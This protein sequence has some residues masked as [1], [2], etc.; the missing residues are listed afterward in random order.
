MAE[1]RGEG[2]QVCCT[3]QTQES[4]MR[5]KQQD[6]LLC[7]LRFTLFCQVPKLYPHQVIVKMYYLVRHVKKKKKNKAKKLK[8][9]KSNFIFLPSVQNVCFW[10][11]V[12]LSVLEAG[13][14][15]LCCHSL[16][17][18]TSAGWRD[19][20]RVVCT[21][22]CLEQSKAD[23][24]ETPL[25]CLSAVHCALQSSKSLLQ[26]SVSGMQPYS[27]VTA[28]CHGCVVVHSAHSNQGKKTTPVED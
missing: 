9:L 5:T 13:Q 16:S 8:H 17:K 14:G 6:Q 22:Q 15:T 19:A 26:F 12:M 21:L 25:A 7:K 28:V 24:C 10:D 11:L 27:A 20:P 4:E 1:E 3:C 23:Q 18:P 2:P